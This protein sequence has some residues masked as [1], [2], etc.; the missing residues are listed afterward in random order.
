MEPLL[1]LGGEGNKNDVT[2][3]FVWR[4]SNANEETISIFRGEN[5][6]TF[7]ILY[8]T[9]TGTIGPILSAVTMPTYGYIPTVKTD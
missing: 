4:T 9:V 5:F 3:Q 1:F 6:V 8:L 7:S 2:V